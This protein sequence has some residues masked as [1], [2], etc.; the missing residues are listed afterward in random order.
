[1]VN[2]I[3]ENDLRKL[4]LKT[5]EEHPEVNLTRVADIYIEQKIIKDMIYEQG[6]PERDARRKGK[7]I[8]SNVERTLIQEAFKLSK[9]REFDFNIN[10]MIIK[11]IVIKV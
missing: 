1:M 6:I 2:I 11:R 3:K 10:S 4:L 8:Y 9:G 5:L 7:E